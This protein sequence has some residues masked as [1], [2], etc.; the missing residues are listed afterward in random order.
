ML[1]NVNFE[2]Y[3][4]ITFT[5]TFYHI[6]RIQGTSLFKNKVKTQK[7]TKLTL[8]S[9]VPFFCILLHFSPFNI[10]TSV[11]LNHQGTCGAEKTLKID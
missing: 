3:S 11:N 9:S 6:K 4:W 10:P 1:Y 7:E 5:S 2:G 8:K